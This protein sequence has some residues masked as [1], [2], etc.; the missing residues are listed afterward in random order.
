MTCDGWV[1]AD[2]WMTGWQVMSLPSMAQR[3]AMRE[4]S[5]GPRSSQNTTPSR[6]PDPTQRPGHGESRAVLKVL[7]ECDEAFAKL[8][9]ITCEA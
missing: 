3:D 1:A 5:H 2:E 7:T 9:R 6:I 8:L 4:V